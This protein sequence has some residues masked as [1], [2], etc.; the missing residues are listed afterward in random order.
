[1][2][3]LVVLLTLALCAAFA[4]A[5]LAATAT[6]TYAT[7]ATVAAAGTCTVGSGAAFFGTI[8]PPITANIEIANSGFGV[9]CPN[10]TPYSIALSAGG[11]GN[12]AQ[13]QMSEATTPTDKLNYNIYTDSFFVS[14]W[15]DGTGSTATVSANGNGSQQAYF[16]G[17]RV[18]V[19]PTPP[20]GSYADVVTITVTF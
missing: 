9:N 6:G 8:T 10:G 4:G 1:M 14:I 5:A 3:K 16:P 18:P 13:R 19:Q 11:S 17:V 15:G 2:K 20:A 7:T 12:F